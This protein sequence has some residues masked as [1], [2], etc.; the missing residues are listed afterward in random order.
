MNIDVPITESRIISSLRLPLMLLVVFLHCLRSDAENL[1]IIN[2]ES[3]FRFICTCAMPLFMMIFGYLV[4]VKKRIWSIEKYLTFLKSRF[5][6]IGIPYLF[7]ISFIILFFFCLQ[8]IS[9]DIERG[10]WIIS[11]WK[12]RQWIDAYGIT[13]EQPIDYQF[14]YLRDLML[15]IIIVPIIDYL[16]KNYSLLS[17]ILTLGGF[18][19]FRIF[20]ELNNFFCALAYFSFGGIIGEKFP[21]FNS[22]I[23]NGYCLFIIFF[24]FL[25][26]TVTKY[27]ELT[28]ITWVLCYV[29]I[30]KTAG[31]FTSRFLF[32]QS[33]LCACFS[34]FLYCFKSFF[35]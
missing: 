28:P 25:V 6:S 15:F 8:S 4:F 22:Y 31:F 26:V 30:L 21:N 2:I 17:I 20:G 12:L 34:M 29:T 32:L 35:H 13:S 16:H 9:K 5:Y 19:Y 33:Q 3:C 10:P 24:I 1:F 7:W 14:W 23:K 18:F 11:S 27:N